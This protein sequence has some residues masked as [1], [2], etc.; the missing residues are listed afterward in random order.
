MFR[1]ACRTNYGCKQIFL[2][3]AVRSVW[4]EHDDKS[5]AESTC[6]L[7]AQGGVCPSQL[8]T[9]RTGESSCCIVGKVGSNNSDSADVKAAFKWGAAWNWMWSGEKPP[10]LRWFGGSHLNMFQLPGVLRPS[11]IVAFRKKNWWA[12][13]LSW[14]LRRMRTS[15]GRW[16]CLWSRRSQLWRPSW[17]PARTR[18]RSWRPQ[19]FVSASLLQFKNVHGYRRKRL[20]SGFFGEPR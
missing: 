18:W 12:P 1:L 19:R 11:R 20:T 8:R 17:P 16:W 2:K 15:C 5:E 13:L 4:L 10:T 3:T 7:T 14:R 6:S 9:S